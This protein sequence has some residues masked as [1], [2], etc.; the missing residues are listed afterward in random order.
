LFFAKFDKKKAVLIVVALA[1]LLFAIILIAGSLKPR[2]N[3]R[4]GFVKHKTSAA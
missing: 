4:F 3:E 1:V 2:Q